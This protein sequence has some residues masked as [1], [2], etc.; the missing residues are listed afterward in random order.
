MSVLIACHPM[1]RELN[2]WTV[3]AIATELRSFYPTLR[4]KLVDDCEHN[5]VKDLLLYQTHQGFQERQSSPSRSAIGDLKHSS[6]LFVLARSRSTRRYIQNQIDKCS[7]GGCNG[8][9]DLC[10]QL[11]DKRGSDYRGNGESRKFLYGY[12]SYDLH[13]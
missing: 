12:H 1:E 7:G 5:F 11:E 8:P 13:I 6:I 4:T 3:S 10:G 9:F 2:L